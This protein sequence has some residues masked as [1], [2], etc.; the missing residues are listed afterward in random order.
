MAS[1]R[2]RRKLRPDPRLGDESSSP[3][4]EQLARELE[5]LNGERGADPRPDQLMD[6]LQVFQEELSVQNAQLRDAQLELEQS[7]DKFADLYHFAPIPILTLN[8]SGLILELNLAASILLRRPRARL[9]GLTFIQFTRD[10]RAFLDFL[11][12]CRAYTGGPPPRILLTLH[13]AGDGDEEREVELAAS[14]R[15][16]DGKEAPYVLVAV[17]DHTERRRLERERSQADEEREN[18]RRKE[19]VAAA[20][21]QAKDQFLAR[22]SHELRTPLTPVL[23]ALSDPKLVQQAPPEF[24][25]ALIMMRRD[26][27]LEIRLIDDLLDVT[28]IARNRLVVVREPV[29][30]HVAIGEVASMLAREASMRGVDL[31]TRRDAAACWVMGDATR[32]RQVLW[33]N[34]LKFSSR[35]GRVTIATENSPDGALE[36]R[37]TD[38]GRGMDRATVASLFDVDAGGMGP[39]PPEAGLGLGLAICEGLVRAHGGTIRAASA[40]PNRGS[41]F[42]IV[43]PGAFEEKPAAAG[44]P[45]AT[46]AGPRGPEQAPESVHILLVEDDEDTAAMMSALLGLHGY[47]V[48][49]AQS[50]ADAVRRSTERQ[51]DLLISDIRLPDGTGLDLRRQLGG[52]AARHAIA[53]SGFGSPDD[54][55]RSL[56][57]GFDEH[58]VKPLDM[59]VLLDAIHRYC[60]GRGTTAAAR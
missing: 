60:G 23:A 12:Q 43:L 46:Q 41:T 17:I 39:L 59:V 28:R 52:D 24:R 16:A 50:V 5:R 22:L 53:V 32:L 10:R 49:V 21:A 38:A 36:V 11:R 3:A 8:P 18:F 30:M 26:V 6:E 15:P 58:L 31:A 29:D 40:G 45:A 9:E 13:L 37:V 1:H 2:S 35:D 14:P 54:V 27:E 55:R 42:T 44:H 47:Q 48:E 4:G 7:R 20:S 57:A 25:E 56:E 51:W 34:G 19:L 33:N